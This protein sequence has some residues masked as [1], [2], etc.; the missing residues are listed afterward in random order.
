MKKIMM[1]LAFGATMI[2]AQASAGGS[3]PAYGYW[4]TENRRAIVEIAPCGNAACGK[5]IWSAQPRDETGHMKLDIKNDDPTMRTR[6]I[7]GIEL[8][9]GFK[10]AGLGRWEDGWI[11]NPRDGQK[12]TALLRALGDQMLEVR[13]YLGFEFLGKSQVWT[14]V[15]DDRGGC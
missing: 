6:P 10:T 4:L 13:G 5:L 8:I 9:G 12:Y 2:G 3:D 14:R 11:Y 15:P 1:M 7:C